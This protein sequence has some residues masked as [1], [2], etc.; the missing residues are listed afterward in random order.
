MKDLT[1]LS[2]KDLKKLQEEID[3]EWKRRLWKRR[4]QS[5]KC[6]ECAFSSKS[7]DEVYKHLIKVHQYAD[8]DASLGVKEIYIKEETK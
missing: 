2:D 8:E 7:E 3:I 6:C 1:K 4:P 5:Y